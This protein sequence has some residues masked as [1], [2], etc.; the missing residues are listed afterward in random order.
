MISLEKLFHGFVVRDS[1]EFVRYQFA[2]ISQTQFSLRLEPLTEPIDGDLQDECSGGYQRVFQSAD[3]L[4]LYPRLIVVRETI[5][6]NS[7]AISFARFG[8]DSEGP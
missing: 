1:A 7:V 3:C 5:T 8:L 2:L 4:R 6:P